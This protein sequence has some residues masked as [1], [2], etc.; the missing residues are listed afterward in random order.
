MAYWFYVKFKVDTGTLGT[1]FFFVNI[2]AGISALLA[3]KI[4]RRFGL[5]NTMVFTHLPSNILLCIIPLM[6]TL[7]LAITVLL[8]RFTISQMDV[9]TRQAYIMTVVTPDERSSASG[10]TSIARSVG[11]SI[12]PSLSGIFLANS[13]LMNFPFFAAGILKIIYDIWIYFSFKKT[14]INE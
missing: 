7:T 13:A 4:D 1:V 6:P 9:P 11:A 14:K 10:V 3:A 12:S 2:F 8:L 5:L